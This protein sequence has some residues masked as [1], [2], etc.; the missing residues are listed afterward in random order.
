[1]SW[2]SEHTIQ[3][4]EDPPKTAAAVCSVPKHTSDGNRQLL[5]F[6]CKEGA[7]KQMTKAQGSLGNILNFLSS[8]TQRTS[9]CHE[10]SVTNITW[11]NVEAR[12]A[13]ALKT[14]R[15]FLAMSEWMSLAMA[16]EDLKNPARAQILPV[17]KCTTRT[18][19]KDPMVI[20]HEALALGKGHLHSKALLR[21]W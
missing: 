7:K 5:L 1:M 16:T 19:L 2:L 12:I 18:G 8:C 9:L 14:A 4:T 21:H 15:S 6:V 11:G 3:D 10:S 13:V 20:L 17:V